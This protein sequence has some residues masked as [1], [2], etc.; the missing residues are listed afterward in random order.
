MSESGWQISYKSSFFRDPLEYSESW[1]CSPPS[2]DY[3]LNTLVGKAFNIQPT[4]EEQSWASLG[5]T[6]SFLSFPFLMTFNEV[7]PTLGDLASYWFVPWQFL[8][9]LQFIALLISCIQLFNRPGRILL[10]C[11]RG[12]SYSVLFLPAVFFYTKKILDTIHAPQFIK[13]K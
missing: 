13:A 12:S 5:C 8:P 11:R 9:L 7:S 3:T 1:L 2:W 10:L 4:D 6:S